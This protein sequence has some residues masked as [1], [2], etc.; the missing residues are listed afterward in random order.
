MIRRVLSLG[1]ENNDDH[2]Q[3]AVN[4]IEYVLTR[5]GYNGSLE[6]KDQ[7]KAHFHS[8]W[9]FLIHTYLKS[10]T[11]RRGTVDKMS[12]KVVYGVIGIVISR[13]YN[14]VY[15]ILK[16]LRYNSKEL[17]KTSPISTKNSRIGKLKRNA[18]KGRETP[19]FDHMKNEGVEVMEE[20][21]KLIS[22]EV[23]EEEMDQ[24]LFSP[25]IQ[26]PAQSL[27]SP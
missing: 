23:D 25:I 1:D 15:A 16:G 7:V 5:M 12:N 21:K 4:Y 19:L 3:Y 14:Y 6:G 8:Q 20:A 11:S 22:E 27:K 9:R 24:D 18:Y 26:S 2:I 10:K 17:K 13:P